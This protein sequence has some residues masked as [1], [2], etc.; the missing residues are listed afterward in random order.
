MQPDIEIRMTSYDYLNAHRMALK[1]AQ[2]LRDDAQSCRDR[3]VYQIWILNAERN[4]DR[5]LAQIEQER[6]NPN[7]S[8]DS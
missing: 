7:G 1:T 5:W 8:M 2:H 6:G 4:I 3:I